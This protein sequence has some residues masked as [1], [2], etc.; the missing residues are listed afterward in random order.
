MVFDLAEEGGV[1]SRLDRC[2]W[3]C[4]VGSQGAFRKGVSSTGWERARS[5]LVPELGTALALHF[6]GRLHPIG[7]CYMGGVVP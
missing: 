1:G 2:D 3:L 5:C 7:S 4:V 6:G